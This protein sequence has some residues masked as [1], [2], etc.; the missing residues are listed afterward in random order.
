[1]TRLHAE[2]RRD[3]RGSRGASRARHQIS[4]ISVGLYLKDQAWVRRPTDS[5]WFLTR[6]V[7]ESSSDKLRREAW[8]LLGSLGLASGTASEG[9][10]SR[11]STVT[12]QWL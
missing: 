8:A 1:M 11:M 3:S 5:L 2:R 9:V 12:E 6:R 7:K 4:V 10:E